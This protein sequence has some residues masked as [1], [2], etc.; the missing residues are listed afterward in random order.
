MM[1]S[2]W[3]T[4]RSTARASA[5]GT[6]DHEGGFVLVGVL[7]TSQFA[8][9][10]HLDESQEAALL[11]LDGQQPASVTFV[12]SRSSC[13]TSFN[14]LGIA[15][16]RNEQFKEAVAVLEKSLSAS[17][18]QSDAFDLFFLAM[19]LARLGDAAKAKDCYDRAARWFRE[20]RGHLSAGWIA[21]LSEFQAEA[22]AQ[23]TQPATVTK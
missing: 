5:C 15:L 1:G 18:G 9:T 23:V 14:T 2:D 17:R 22:E 11:Q 6:K 21:E 19:C 12:P 10:A 3:I 8:A 20:H 13:D 16:Y 4:C 7:Q